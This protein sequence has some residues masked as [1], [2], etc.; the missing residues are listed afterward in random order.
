MPTT[1]TTTKVTEGGQPVIVN[2]VHYHYA[3]DPAL[4]E[5]MGKL[6]EELRLRMVGL[7]GDVDALAQLFEGRLTVL[8]GQFREQGERMM[9]AFADIETRLRE[10]TTVGDGMS[11]LLSEL[12]GRVR[13]LAEEARA[14]ADN[15]TDAQLMALA[16]EMDQKK[17]AWAQSIMANTIAADEDQGGAAEPVPADPAPAPAPVDP[18]APQPAVGEGTAEVP[19]PEANVIGPSAAREVPNAM[20]QAGEQPAGGEGS[21]PDAGTTAPAEQPQTTPAAPMQP[22][23]PAPGQV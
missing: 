15:G 9:V 1:E 13:T 23:N 5:A 6:Q 8:E 10:L 14:R 3:H 19:A 20:R 16:D 21:G 4:V 12:S 11:T 7:Q 18:A 2:N 22:G 17:Q